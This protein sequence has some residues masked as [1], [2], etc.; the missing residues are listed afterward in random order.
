MNNQIL[1]SLIRRLRCAGALPP[2]SAVAG[3]CEP[4]HK[5]GK[6]RLRGE[7]NRMGVGSFKGRRAERRTQKPVIAYPEDFRSGNLKL[8]YGVAEREESPSTII[9]VGVG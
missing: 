1:G 9:D 4:K 2:A 6:K 8:P 7:P 3:G 5:F